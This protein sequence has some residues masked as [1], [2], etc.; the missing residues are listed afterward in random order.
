MTV[1][2]ALVPYDVGMD[3]E[4]VALDVPHFTQAAS[5]QETDWNSHPSL[6]KQMFCKMR[7]AAVLRLATV[8]PLILA[9]GASQLVAWPL[10]LGW[11][12]CAAMAAQVRAHGPS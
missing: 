6:A 1:I 4:R 12:A 5:T 9:V 11:W 8:L 2:Q 3:R 10:R 7:C